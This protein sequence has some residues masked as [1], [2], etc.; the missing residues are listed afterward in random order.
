MDL[1]CEL[2][3]YLI[4]EPKS[5]QKEETTNQGGHKG[6]MNKSS[7]Q[8]PPLIVRNISNKERGIPHERTFS[9][10][11]PLPFR[12]THFEIEVAC[13]HC[14]AIDTLYL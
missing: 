7:S 5:M 9:L 10:E 8:T 6:N 12:T 14:N 4:I 13:V 3:I 11:K 2:V 1:S